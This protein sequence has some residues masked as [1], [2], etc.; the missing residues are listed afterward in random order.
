MMPRFS[1]REREREREERE[2]ERRERER[3]ERRGRHLSRYGRDRRFLPD[4]AAAQAASLESVLWFSHHVC[5]PHLP[6]TI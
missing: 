6:P 1:E 4:Y 5:H 3:R 2:R